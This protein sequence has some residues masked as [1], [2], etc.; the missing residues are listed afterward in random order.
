MNIDMAY[1]KETMLRI[2]EIPSPSGDTD[3]AMD[4]VK[5][6]FEKLGVSTRMTNKKALIATI[7][8]ED[9]ENQKTIAVHI[10]TLGAIVREIKQNG[11]L[12]IL[13]IGGFAWTAFEGENV[14]I[15]TLKGETYTGSL[16]PEKASI[17]VYS[18]EVRETLRTDENME[19]RIDEFVKNKE[20]VLNLGINVGDFVYFEPR[21]VIT[22]RGFIKSRFLDDKVCVAIVFGLVKYLKDHNVEPKYTTHFYI[23]NYEETGHGISYIPEKTKEFLALDIGLVAPN[24]QSDE[25]KVTICARDSRT[26]YDFGFRK[27]LV[28]ICKLNNIDY[29]VDVYF[30][31]G[32]DASVSVLQGFDVN[33]ACI[34]PGVDA[35]HHYERTHIK[36]IEETIKLLI[37]YITA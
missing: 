24:Q 2:L 12:K 9:N 30:R 32:S 25:T 20:D 6:E 27:K 16:L 13:P 26:P 28:D 11:R 3:K 1:M 18:E 22:Q 36:A 7:E 19:I 15:K 17:H 33:F 34:G 23:S 35:T 21:T 4:Y 31:Y 5:R 8:G 10:D 29:V 14:I 37:K